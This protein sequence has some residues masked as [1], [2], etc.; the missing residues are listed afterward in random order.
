M[1]GRNDPCWCGSKKKW[2]K[3]HYP[4]APPLSTNQLATEYYKKYQIRLKTPEEITKIRAACKLTK[5][6]L[7]KT[8]AMAKAGVTTKEL[9]DYANKLMIEA[10]GI[11]ATLNYGNPPYPAS[12]CISLNEVICHGIPSERKFIEGDIANIDISVILDGCFGD[13]SAMVVIG[14]TTKERQ[15]VV[16]VAYESLMKSISILKP[17]VLLSQIGDV[18]TDYATSKGCSVV[19]QFVG[20]GVGLA[21]HE[22]PQVLHSRNNIHIP[23]TAGMT[24]TIEP[25]INAGKPEGTIQDDGWTA[26]TVDGKASAQWEHTIL[27]TEDGHEILTS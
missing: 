13:C 24:F 22:P 2:K 16:D 20:H 7:N 23:L 11:P 17:G 19:Y 10:G 8:C 25:M 21:F 27:I 18:I 1:Y 15:L 26:L 4:K 3:C 12:S 6:I 5:S 9:D 14:E